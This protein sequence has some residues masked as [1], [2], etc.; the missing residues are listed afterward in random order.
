MTGYSAP[1]QAY[2]R[3]TLVKA[4]DWIA[5]QPESLRSQATNADTLVGLYLQTKRRNGGSVAMSGYPVSGEAFTEDLKSLARDL[6]QF[7]APS[8]TPQPPP[9]Q[10]APQMPPPA[11]AHPAAPP[12]P[13]VQA[14]VSHHA[15][16]TPS[17]PRTPQWSVDPKSWAQAQMIKERLN[18]SSE[19]EAIRMM[20]AL[21]AERLNGLIS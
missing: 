14:P 5:H 12:A 16:P 13:P 2:T 4:I 8:P 6:E 19:S 18:L 3:D 15:S 11:A 17:A 7:S 9:P 10:A 1:P 21:G 20:I